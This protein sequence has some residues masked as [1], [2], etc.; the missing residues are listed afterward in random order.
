MTNK[1]YLDANINAF[2]VFVGNN[3]NNWKDKEHML[4][5]LEYYAH[6]FGA[7]I[8]KDGTENDIVGSSYSSVLVAGTFGSSIG[9]PVNAKTWMGW[10]RER[11]N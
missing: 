9:I 8:A 11:I 1:E 7:G 6:C 3:I 2:K 10:I 4:R 5:D